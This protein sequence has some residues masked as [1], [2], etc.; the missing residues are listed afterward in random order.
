MQ[1]TFSVKRSQSLVLAVLA[2]GLVGQSQAFVVPSAYAS[3]IGTAGSLILFGTQARTYQAQV[4]ASELGGITVGTKIYS[5]T[6]RVTSSTQQNNSPA[7]NFSSWNMQL[8]KATNSISGMSA[9]FASNMS[10]PITVK[11]GPLSLAAG[12]FQG[13]AITSSPRPWGAEIVFDTP[14]TYTGGD[15]VM[16]VSRPVPTGTTESI[17]A[18]AVGSTTAGYGTQFR[19][20]STL[21]EGA[22]VATN[23]TSSFTIGRFST[24]PVPEPATL[25][26]LGSGVAGLLSRRR[27]S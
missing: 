27:R 21:A 1:T 11:S 9:T 25:L 5:M 2:M 20:L 19:A 18:D 4:A 22:T 15:L 26:L 3:S 8:A 23:L 6:V 13:G 12:A 10:N 17:F 14:Y 16:M 24:Q 7:M